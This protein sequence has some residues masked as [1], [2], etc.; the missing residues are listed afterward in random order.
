MSR[1]RVLLVS[2]TVGGVWTY[3][4]ELARALEPLGI[5]PIIAVAGPLP[6]EEHR[7]AAGGIPLI[8][9]S[10][11]LEWLDTDA[12]EI[13]R[14]GEELARIA[15]R[16]RVDVVQTS[17]A[18]ILADAPLD[19]SS[20][21]VQ[22]S[23]VATW[24]AATKGTPLPPEFKWRRDFVKRG[25]D[26]ADIVV[27]PTRAFA[28]ATERSYGSE[29]S[30]VHNGRTAYAARDLPQ[31]DFAFAAGRLWDEGKNVATLDRAAASIDAPF[32]VAGPTL[33]PNGASV[34]L[35]HLHGLGELSA[36]RVAGL[37]AARPVF[38][39]AALYEPFG[40]SAI[41]A[42]QAGCALVLSDIP[43]HRELWEGA[44]TFVA[45]RDDSAFA[46]AIS[47]LL[48]NRPRRNELGDRARDR[49][50]RYTP[51][52]MARGMAEI[53]ARLTQPQLLAGAA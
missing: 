37:L 38:V 36:D 44:A 13:A 21:A 31:G 1:L 17:S 5:D 33:G 49:A 45:P 18:A 52:Q 25:L 16:E 53:Y 27:A 48:A 42:A 46:D 2:D 3:S 20:V 40:L 35:D 32:Q 51:E 50:R 29:V 22:H 19:C 30:A 23:C 4:I 7:R 41:E 43:T 26:R 28:E 24:W 34:A 39:S 8:D 6:S 14:A 11:P 9:T 15:A 47:D 12:D 10:L